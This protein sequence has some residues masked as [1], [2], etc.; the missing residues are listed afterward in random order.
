MLK[1]SLLLLAASACTHAVAQ[2]SAPPDAHVLASV[3]VAQAITTGSLA[4]SGTR[5]LLGENSVITALAR[6]AHVTL[7]RGGD[8]LV[9]QTSVTHLTGSR[10]ATPGQEDPLLISLDRGAMELHLNFSSADAI[11]TPDLRLTSADARS[12]PLELSLRITPNG[13]TCVESRGKKAPILMISDAFGQ[14]SYQLKPGQHVLF[15]HGSL[16][17]VVDTET[18]SCGCPPPQSVSLA[19]AALHG[20]AGASKDFPVA[21]SQGLAPTSPPPA[22]KPGETKVQVAATL[23]YN[24]DAAPDAPAPPTADT[25]PPASPP[26]PPPPAAPRKDPLHAVGRFF[27]RLFVR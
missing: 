8:L 19:D 7:F 2:S 25:H 20:G 22:D 16:S 13:D 3:P 9:C 26:A 10:P 17:A 23:T 14:A 4:V 11:L 24:P 15:E 12:K 27:K 5:S 21:A 18:S 1:R 6:P